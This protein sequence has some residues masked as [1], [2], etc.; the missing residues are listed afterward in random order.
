M[1][2]VPL[3][4]MELLP[5]PRIQTPTER[6]QL[7]PGRLPHS[8]LHESRMLKHAE[9]RHAEQERLP[10]TLEQDCVVIPPLQ[11]PP[12]VGAEDMVGLVVGGGTEG[13]TVGESV[14]ACANFAPLVHPTFAHDDP[15][16]CCAARSVMPSRSKSANT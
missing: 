11:M 10:N 4:R 3:Q 6:S 5:V 14:A 15:I 2:L 1:V 13:A 8:A 12:C 7:H 9:L 16:F